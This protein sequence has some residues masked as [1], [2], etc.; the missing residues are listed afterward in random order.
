[1][2]REI[3]RAP[4]VLV[5]EDEALIQ[6]AVTEALSDA[7]YRTCQASTGAEALAKLVEAEGHALLVLLDLRLPDVRDLWLVRAVRQR[8]PDAPLIVMS[9][10][11]NADDIAQV[12]AAGAVGLLEKPFDMT[13]VVTAIDGACTP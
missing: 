9:A 3:C 11:A 1:M 2:D 5:V 6:W 7:G 12:I 10:H 13:T 8:R 4:T